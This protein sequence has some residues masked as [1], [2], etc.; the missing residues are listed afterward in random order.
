MFG[1]T[2]IWQGALCGFVMFQT[3]AG[4]TIALSTYKAFATNEHPG[5]AREK[6]VRGFGRLLN[7]ASQFE[8]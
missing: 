1:L 2:F 7:Y 3:T 4:H 5:T 6:R 8:L